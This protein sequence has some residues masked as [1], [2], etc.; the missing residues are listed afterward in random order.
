MSAP[1]RVRFAEDADQS[2]TVTSQESSEESDEHVE[3]VI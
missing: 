3:L 1:K 2:D